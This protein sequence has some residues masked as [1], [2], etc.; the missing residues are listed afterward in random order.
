[1]NSRIPKYENTKIPEILEINT[2]SIVASR[3]SLKQQS[4]VMGSVLCGPNMYDTWTGAFVVVSACVA[5][6]VAGCV[7]GCVVGAC[8]CV[9][10]STGGAGVDAA[11]VM[12]LLL[13]LLVH[14]LV[15][16]VFVVVLMVVSICVWEILPA[17]A[18][19]YWFG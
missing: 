12:L 7:V 17:C 18:L 13:G 10:V 8:V 6:C 16:V 3:M 11:L 4:I 14:P 1:M 2:R 19:G 5:G 9:C 15:L